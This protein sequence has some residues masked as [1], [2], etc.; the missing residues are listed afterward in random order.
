MLNRNSSAEIVLHL[1]FGGLPGS[2]APGLDQSFSLLISEEFDESVPLL[3]V[4]LQTL[5]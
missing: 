4:V 2:D 3:D 5:L 1:S